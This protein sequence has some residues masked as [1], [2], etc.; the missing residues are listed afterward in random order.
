MT[1]GADDTDEEEYDD[2]VEVLFSTNS[3][4]TLHALR[5]K[6]HSR[7]RGNFFI[8]TGYYAEFFSATITLSKISTDIFPRQVLASVT[9]YFLCG[10]EFNQFSQ[11]K[12]P[13]V[14]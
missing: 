14:V 4:E 3:F 1:T 7:K 5:A 12:E 2:D 9:I 8:K 6:P 10:A 13:D 11:V